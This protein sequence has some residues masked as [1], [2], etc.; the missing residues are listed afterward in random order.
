MKKNQQQCGRIIQLEKDSWFLRLME[1]RDTNVIPP[2]VGPSTPDVDLSI[3]R[4]RFL[5]ALGYARCDTGVYAGYFSTT[6]AR[7]QNGFRGVS[8]QNLK[9]R[10]GAI[11]SL[12]FQ[13]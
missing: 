6:R 9:P 1:I 11:K 2:E 3:T 8:K 5:C 4:L 13:W 10:P 7:A 12:V